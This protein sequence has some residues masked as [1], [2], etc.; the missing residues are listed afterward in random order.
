M[1][2]RSFQVAACRALG[3]ARGR[4]VVPARSNFFCQVSVPAC[5]SFDGLNRSFC[6]SPPAEDK[7]L[8]KR[9]KRL[10][11]RA[12]SRGWLEL[13]VLMG[14]FAEKNVFVM[15]N[16]RLDLLEEILELEN[17]DLFKWFTGQVPV[18]EE[19]KENPVM[20]ELLEFI[21]K[22]QEEFRVFR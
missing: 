22:D 18:P 1:A 17:P 4:F 2:S 6:T 5:S 8:Y 12:K 11:F 16:D 14:T 10:L 21:G 20:V 3:V 13:D 19:I 15:D 9:R 7:E